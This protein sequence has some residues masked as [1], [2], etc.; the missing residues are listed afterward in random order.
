MPSWA[1]R[2]MLS[3]VAHHQAARLA[4]AA[5]QLGSY[6]SITNALPRV[7]RQSVRWARLFVL[8]VLPA[9]LSA[10]IVVRVESAGAPVGRVDVSIWDAAG[11]LGLGRTSDAGVVRI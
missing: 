8:L 5:V 6:M 1:P 3:E 4:V 2:G 7:A 9:G 11:R 10:Q